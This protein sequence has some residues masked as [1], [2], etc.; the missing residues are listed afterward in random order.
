ML[1][2]LDVGDGWG[3]PLS[4][5]YAMLGRGGL[6]FVV[7]FSGLCV[8]FLHQVCDVETWSSKGVPLRFLLE[9]GG[10]AE[11]GRNPVVWDCIGFTGRSQ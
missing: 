8:E 9:N 5:A 2:M 1:G 7:A 4:G 3:V 11:R 10:R 6:S